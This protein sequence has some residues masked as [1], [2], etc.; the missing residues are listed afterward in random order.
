MYRLILVVSYF[1]LYFS[2]L[3]KRKTLPHVFSTG[4][5]YKLVMWA[6]ADKAATIETQ[7]HL[8]PGNYKHWD[9]IGQLNLTEEWQAF[10]FGDEDYNPGDIR[11]ITGDQ[12]TCQTIAF[13]CNVLKE[14]NNYYFRF[15]DFSFNI[16]DVTLEER[17]LGTEDITVAVPEPGETP[18][19]TSVDFTNCM[20]ALGVELISDLIDNTCLS[21]QRKPLKADEG[22]EAAAGWK[23]VVPGGNMEGEEDGEEQGDDETLDV[24]YEIGLVAATGFPLNYKGL[25]DDEGQMDFEVPEGYT[26]DNVVFNIYNNEAS[27]QGKT[28]DGL[29]F[30]LNDDGWTYRFN[31]TFK[32][33]SAAGKPGDVN[34]DGNVDINDVVAIINVMAGT[35]DWKNAN[36]NGDEQGVDINDVVAVINIMAAQ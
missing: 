14:E 18:A 23:N 4:Q 22:E 19:S 27:F 21:V 11:T 34:E 12:N 35:A 10:V 31:V 17:T 1:Y 25:Y 30:F 16:A 8:M 24:Q 28:A 15:D 20:S 9:M 5:Q 13:N 36:V 29:F 26:A 33:E 3:R 32:G 6:R 2:Y 7:A